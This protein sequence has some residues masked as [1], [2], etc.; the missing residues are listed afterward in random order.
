[1]KNSNL[2]DDMGVIA[3]N[4]RELKFYYNSA[5]AIGKQALGYVKAS[6]KKVLEIDV[7]KTKVTATQWSEL[8]DLL[9]IPIKDVINTEHPDFV[10]KYGENPDIPDENDWLHILEKNPHVFQNPIVVNGDKAIRIETPSDIAQMLD[11]E[12]Q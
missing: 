2:M 8:A 3:T 11:G 5:S 4:K 7:A 6:N 12:E 1:M 9:N 10:S